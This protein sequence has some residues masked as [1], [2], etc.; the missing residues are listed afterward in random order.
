MANAQAQAIELLVVAQ[1]LD[2]IAQAVVAAVATTV[3]ETGGAGG[4]VQLVVG[5]QN[6][7]G[8]NLEKLRHG[9]DRL[10]TAVHKGG[11]NQQAQVLPVQGDAGGQAVEF[12]LGRECRA[13][14]VGQL[15]DKVGTGVVAGA[16]VFG[17]R[18][19]QA[20]NHL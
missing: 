8:R 20:D 2:G 3:L 12:V 15:G 17:A 6:G 5:D 10:T 9:A 16:V 19:T 14:S 4:Q 11:G 7:L 1:G 18:I 13:V